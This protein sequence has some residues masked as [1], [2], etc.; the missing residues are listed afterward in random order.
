MSHLAKY[1]KT[2]KLSA[3]KIIPAEH[4]RAIR[5]ALSTVEEHAAVDDIMKLCLGRKTGRRK[6]ESAEYG[7][8]FQ[9]K[10]KCKQFSRNTGMLHGLQCICG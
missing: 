3:D 10:G 4:V 6:T 9:R 2:G 5:H 1:V 7:K 8:K